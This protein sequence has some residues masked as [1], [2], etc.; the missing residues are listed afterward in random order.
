MNPAASSSSS[1]T[2]P[3]SS[4]PKTNAVMESIEKKTAQK[5]AELMSPVATTDPISKIGF[6]QN[7]G[8]DFGNKLVSIMSQGA[9]EFEQN[10]GRKMTYSEMRA[11]Y[12]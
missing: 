1:N 5:V 11:M 2:L 9:N 6:V 8:S 12:G 4:D 10:M 7:Q 3:L